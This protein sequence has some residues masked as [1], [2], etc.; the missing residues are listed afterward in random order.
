MEEAAVEGAL[1]ML[2]LRDEWL[3]G[4]VRFGREGEILFGGFVGQDVVAAGGI[5]HDP[6]APEPGLGRVRHIYVLRPYRKQGIGRMLVEQ[7]LQH[8][9]Q[10]FTTLRLNT[11]N[12]AAAQLSE[13]LGFVRSQ[14]PH[15]THRLV[16]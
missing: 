11:Q 9:R 4:A 15:Q 16:L 3:N 14:G 13:S 2:R 7:I 8:A 12:P 6:H 10:H 1:F 5:S